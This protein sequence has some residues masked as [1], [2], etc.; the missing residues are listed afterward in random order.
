MPNHVQTQELPAVDRMDIATA[1][2]RNDSSTRTV[3]RWLDQGLPFFQATPRSKILIRPDDV[4]KFLQRRCR[5]P[6]DVNAMVEDTM[7]ELTDRPAAHIRG[8]H[9]D[10]AAI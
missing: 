3:Y 5:P 7:K 10:N 1:A 9:Q 2:R 4:E 6:V 8:K